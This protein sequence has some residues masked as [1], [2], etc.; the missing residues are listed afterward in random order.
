MVTQTPD[1]LNATPTQLDVA[2]ASA[3]KRAVMRLGPYAMAMGQEVKATF[4]PR[5]LL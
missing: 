4:D 2:L 1:V 5:E 3:A